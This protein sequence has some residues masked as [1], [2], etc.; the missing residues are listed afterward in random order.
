MPWMAAFEAHAVDE[1]GRKNARLTP[2]DVREECAPVQVPGQSRGVF[3]ERQDD[4]LVEA[5]EIEP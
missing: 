1:T 4:L 5:A 3:S 2:H